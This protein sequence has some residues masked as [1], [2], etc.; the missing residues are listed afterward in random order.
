MA[1]HLHELFEHGQSVWMDNLSRDILTSGELASAIASGNI[2]G[3][4][5]N[6]AIFEKAIAGNAIYDT[7][8]AEAVQDGKDVQG[9]YETL[10]FADIQAAADLLR[11]VYESS[12]GVDGYVSIEVSPNLAGDTAG[13]IAEAQR[14]WQTLNR[15]NIMIK[16][17]GTAAGF[18]AIEA[19]IAAG[20]PVNVTL[21]FSVADYEQTAMAYIRGLEALAAQGQSVKV[22]SVA[23]FFLSRIDTKIDARL[24]AL[25]ATADETQQAK[26]NSLMG[27]AAIANA[28]M[29]YQRYKEIY[30]TAA[31]QALA[32]QGALEQRLLWASTSTKNPTYSDVMYVDNL[33]GD[34]TVNTMPPETIDACIDHCDV[35]DR[36]EANLDQARQVLADFTELGIDLDVVMQEL[37]TEGIDKFVKPFASLMKSLETKMASLQP[38]SV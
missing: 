25:A 29:A 1:N 11:P 8:I 7:A 26:L 27:K 6:P 10:A 3:I 37:Q 13:T 28:K 5:S 38:T 2:R 14:F 36:L 33:V 19:T 9:V 24:Q 18:P 20:I 12:N 35:S 34:N 31:W 4:T 16:I 15:P 32:A 21:L 17:P 22:A 30:N 23:S